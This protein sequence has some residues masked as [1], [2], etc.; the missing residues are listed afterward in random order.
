MFHAIM[1][2]IIIQVDIQTQMLGILRGLGLRDSVFWASWWIPFIGT[3]VANSLGGAITAA[4]L[5]S[6]AFENIYFMGVFGSFFFLNLALVGASLFLA[7]VCG[8]ARGGAATWNIILILI[9]QWTPYIVQIMATNWVDSPRDLDYLTETPIGLFWVNRDTTNFGGQCEQPIISQAQGSWFKTEEE[10]QNFPEDEFFVGCYFSAG[11][12]S[13]IWNKEKSPGLPFLFMFPYVHFSNIW[14]NFL[15]FTAMPNR[16]FSS[17]HVAMSTEELAIEALPN[18]L[19][20]DKARDSVLFPQGSTLNTE[21]KYYSNYNSPLSNCPAEDLKDY[22]CPMSEYSQCASASEVSPTTSPSVIALFGYL[23]ILS[24][25]YTI[26]AAYWTQVFPGK[27]INKVVCPGN[28][29]APKD[30]LFIAYLLQNGSPRKFY[31]FLLP[32]YWF[33]TKVSSSSE[34]AN[35]VEVSEAR[36]SYGGFQALKGVSMTMASN[37]VTALLGHNGAGML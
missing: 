16:S 26:L 14:G 10:R 37:E 15:G 22:F 11:Y 32:S 21:Q 18:P 27:V 25:I 13:S 7:A 24:V 17:K 4:A 8:T 20:P 35:R 12:I 36:K 30:S 28:S 31:F 6:H 9:A 33:G 19:D 34:T 2:F 5:S 29:I 3:S 1:A 23:F